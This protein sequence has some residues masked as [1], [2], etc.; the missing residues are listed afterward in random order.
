MRLK[1]NA[2]AWI[3]SI[4]IAVVLVVV[5]TES[6]WMGERVASHRA[7]APGGVK[8]LSLPL[9]GFKP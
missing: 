6:D 9:T 5:V 1:H 3:L 2:G 7:A 4:I 8:P